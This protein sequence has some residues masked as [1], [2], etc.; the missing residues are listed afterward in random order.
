MVE[1]FEVRNL[2]PSV[3]FF[4]A[5]L[6]AFLKASSS[7]CPHVGLFV[8]RDSAFR[9]ILTSLYPLLH[10]SL[11]WYRLLCAMSMEEGSRFVVKSSEM[12][13]G[14]SSSD[15]MAE[16]EIDTAASKP[17]SFKPSS[18]KPPSSKNPR[19]FHALNE[20]C[21]LDEDMPFRFKDRFQFSNKTR[22]RLPHKNER[23]CAFGHG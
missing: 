23:A 4:F 11:N 6:G 2:Y 16:M 12:E 20:L 14:L 5:R 15:K 7:H 10:Q 22:I 8:S 3:S 13:T 21:G 1:F 19:S 18:S 9:P 17:S